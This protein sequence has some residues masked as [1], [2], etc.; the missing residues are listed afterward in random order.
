MFRRI[1]VCADGSASAIDAAGTAA[2]VAQRFGAEVLAL[3]VLHS[4]YVD[5]ATIGVWA[6]AVDQD[7]IDRFAKEQREAIEPIIKPIFDRLKIPFRYIQEA[8]LEREVDAILRVAEREKADLIVMGSRGLRG[9]GELLL[10]SVSSGVLHHAVCPVLIVHGDNAPCGT[11]GFKNILLASDG[12]PC[13]QRAAKVAVEMA[14]KFANTLTVLNVYEELSAVSVPGTE[15]NLISAADT[16]AYAKQWLEYVAQPVKALAKE[17]GVNCAFVQQGGHPD[18]AIKRFA[19]VHDVDL[20][21]LGSRGLGG[22]ARLLLGSI[23]NRVLHHANC[24]V[25]VVR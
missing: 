18:E 13:A 8:G 25:L 2:S 24:P 11:A 5:A 6:I 7:M 16:E 15:E 12:S 1:L 3:N 19:T 22:Y 21:V 20:I 4:S 17:A 14:Q 23:S 9:V 10:G